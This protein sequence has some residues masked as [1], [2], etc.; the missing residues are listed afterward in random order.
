LV[1][2]PSSL[3]FPSFL[4]DRQVLE[5]TGR[6]KGLSG[7][8]LKREVEKVLDLTGLVNHARQEDRQL[9]KGMVQKLSIG[10]R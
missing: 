1:T 9:L 3:S 6:L 4:T 5:I 2:R 7:S 10:Q 8:E